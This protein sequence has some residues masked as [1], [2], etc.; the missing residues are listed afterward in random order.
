MIK[1]VIIVGFGHGTDAVISTLIREHTNYSIKIFTQEA[2]LGYQKPPLSKEF[3]SG[4]LNKERIFFRNPEFLKKHNIEVFLSC[5]VKKI[6]ANSKHIELS[7]GNKHSFDALII[8]TGSMPRTLG[9][10]QNPFHLHNLHD[11]ELLKKKKINKLGIIGA[12]F[13][14][15]E[16][17]SSLAQSV[18]EIKI[19][20]R[21]S[22][23]LES[24]CHE[25]IANI[26]TKSLVTSGVH[27]ELNCLIE[28]VKEADKK[29]ILKT[30]DQTYELD[31]VL[32]CIGNYTDTSIVDNA[33]INTNR[34]FMINNFCETSAKDIYAIGDCSEY[35]NPFNQQYEVTTSISHATHQ[36]QIAARNIL[37]IES[38]MSQIPWFWS[39][40]G[41]NRLQMMG[42]THIGNE[43]KSI[44]TSEE[45]LT[46]I[47]S[48]NS[49][50]VGFQ[51]LNNPIHFAKI[52]KI[53][54]EHYTNVEPML[55]E[56]LF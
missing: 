19:F 1:E 32:T 22:R 13:I 46:K 8:A 9:S 28:S 16:V 52:K 18:K 53:M 10:I 44:K 49:R 41:K 51:S 4:S 33:E 7:D 48:H 31:H 43:F 27:I 2:L 5:P 23:V 11:A 38:K 17:A 21:A 26:L 50:V 37:G 20:E 24:V 34:G 54:D 6:Y 56:H 47:Y 45:S 35:Q 30:N 55:I 40:Q 12:G 36:G 25:D 3:L 29:T 42:Y 15:M 39:N 14:G